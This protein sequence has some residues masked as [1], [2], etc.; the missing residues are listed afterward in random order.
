MKNSRHPPATQPEATQQALPGEVAKLVGELSETEHPSRRRK[1]TGAI[2]RLA[3]RSRRVG[4]HGAPA[5]GRG[6]TAPGFAMGRRLPVRDQQT[7]RAQFPGLNTEELADALIQGSA[8]AAAAVGA[9]AGVAMVASL[10]R[11]AG[12]VAIAQPE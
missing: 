2:S 8:R 12:E 4:W 1:L 11:G 3:G 10:P 6:G 9:S 5:G 7:L